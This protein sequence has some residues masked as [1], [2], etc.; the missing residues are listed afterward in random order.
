MRKAHKLNHEFELDLAPLLAVMVKLVPVLLVSSAFMQI[1]V[2]DSKLP[3]PVAKAIAANAANPHFQLKVYVQTK[4][5]LKIVAEDSSGSHSD[6]TVGKLPDGSFDYAGY[7]SALERIKENH[8][9]QFRLELYPDKNVAYRDL[10]R[11]MD[12]A[13][14]PTDPKK[15]YAFGDASTNLMFPDVV[16]ANLNENGGGS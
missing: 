12:Y 7:R 15:L 10:V 4:G 3:E 1:M 6:I 16:F 9:D 14:K 5:D 8:P 11:L 2:I 13:R